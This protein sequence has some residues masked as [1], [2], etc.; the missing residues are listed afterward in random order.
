MSENTL[1]ELFR[2]IDELREDIVGLKVA[3]EHINTIH[4]EEE[5]RN[6]LFFAVFTTFGA[7]AA[8]LLEGLAKYWGG[9]R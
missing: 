1:R 3:V 2:K 6:K 4:C 8:W 7:C 9:W 5:K